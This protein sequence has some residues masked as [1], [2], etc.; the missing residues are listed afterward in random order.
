M[1]VLV[2]ATG[3][4]SVSSRVTVFAAQ[5]I[6]VQL[7]YP[8]LMSPYSFKCASTAAKKPLSCRYRHLDAGFSLAGFVLAP[9]KHQRLLDAGVVLASED[10]GGRLADLRRWRRS[11]VF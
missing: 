7:D 10:A 5:F 2:L 9:S 8:V 11:S 6:K 3:L 4:Q 1:L